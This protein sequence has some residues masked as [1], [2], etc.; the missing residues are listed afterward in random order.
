MILTGCRKELDGDSDW[1][2]EE[3]KRE[4]KALMSLPTTKERGEFSRSC[5]FRKEA[6]L[7]VRYGQ[8]ER[9]KI[10]AKGSAD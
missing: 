8:D 1:M 3:E 7:S 6:V 9:V 10:N 2:K 4:E 5:D